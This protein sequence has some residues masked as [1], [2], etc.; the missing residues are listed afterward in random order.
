MITLTKTGGIMVGHPA[1]TQIVP[2]NPLPG[3]EYAMDCGE[4]VFTIPCESKDPSDPQAYVYLKP[5]HYTVTSRY[6]E[7]VERW[8]DGGH[9][10]EKDGEYM[11]TSDCFNEL[12]ALESGMQP[13]IP[14][15]A[16]HDSDRF[17]GLFYSKTAALAYFNRV[18]QAQGKSDL[19][20]LSSRDMDSS[21][22]WAGQ[23]T[24]AA[25]VR[26]TRVLTEDSLR[27]EEN[28]TLIEQ[29]FTA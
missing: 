29:G 18:F 5:E 2:A 28:I 11:D 23:A 24:E 10:I 13:L 19:E 26:S 16:I 12:R 14:V 21:H 8:S 22:G 25:Q 9:W 20:F 7:Q 17:S 6:T 3:R 15:V 1:G 4:K 27:E